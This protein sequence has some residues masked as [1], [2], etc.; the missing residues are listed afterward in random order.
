MAFIM[1]SSDWITPMEM[2]RDYYTKLENENKQFF[3]MNGMGHTPFIDDP[4]KF[5]EN[6]CRLLK[7]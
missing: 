2:A 5:A 1:G 3:I 7:K 4:I 6:V